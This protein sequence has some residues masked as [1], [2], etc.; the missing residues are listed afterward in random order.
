MKTITTKQLREDMP[1]IVRAIKQGNAIKLSYRKQIIG[2]V[3]PVNADGNELQ[4]GSAQAISAFLKNTD[5]GASPQVKND[6]RNFEE[7]MADLRA[8][9]LNK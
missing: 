8:K 1:N 2:V 4:R 7:Q 9:D 3:Q 6:S 5:F